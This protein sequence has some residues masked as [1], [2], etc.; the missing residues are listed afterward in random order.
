MTDNKSIYPN[1]NELQTIHKWVVLT[2]A[3]AAAISYVV[4]K[5]WVDVSDVLNCKNIFIAWWWV[6]FV[7]QAYHMITT[8]VEKSVDKLLGNN[9]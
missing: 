5:I 7:S 4:Q 3:W 8:H 9:S 6:L 2:T 1:T